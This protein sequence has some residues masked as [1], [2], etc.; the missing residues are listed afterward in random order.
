M[1]VQTHWQGE[2]VMTSQPAQVYLFWFTSR[3]QLPLVKV[4]VQTPTRLMA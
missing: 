3:G 4:L 1:Q 2:F